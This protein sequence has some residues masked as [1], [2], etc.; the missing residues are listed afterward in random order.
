MSKI[1]TA[2]NGAMRDI[3]KIGIG[4]TKTADTGMAKYKFRGIEDAM[5]EMS[6]IMVNHGI[7]VCARYSELAITERDKG[8]GK[9]TR[10]VT[11]KGSFTFAAEDDSTV[12]AEAYGEAMDSGDKATIKAQSV[13]FRTALFQLFVVPTMSMDS[14]LDH[15][16]GEEGNADDALLAE[17]RDVALNGA[18]ALK[19]HFEK[20]KPAPA[21]W[22]RYSG[23]LKEAARVVDAGATQ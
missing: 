16:E 22:A 10:F 15:G 23:S 12:T 3:A 21:F 13:A 2:I 9:A 20:V 7:T 1:Q 14:E 19:A 6:P 17:F 5:N 8:G 18:A 4:K 11:L